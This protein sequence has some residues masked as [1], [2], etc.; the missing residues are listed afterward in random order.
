[1]SSNNND[2][3]IQATLKKSEGYYLGHIPLEAAPK[4]IHFKVAAADIINKK[5]GEMT[6]I[7]DEGIDEGGKLHPFEIH[8]Y[9]QNLKET[10]DPKKE[11]FSTFIFIG[12]QHDSNPISSKRVRIKFSSPN[13]SLQS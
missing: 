1:M 11:Y 8:F 2:I 10:P 6:Y 12:P 7:Y 5:Q 3:T 13:M 9:L 4:D